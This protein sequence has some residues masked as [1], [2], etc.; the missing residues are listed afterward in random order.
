MPTYNTYI[1]TTSY[2]Y[3]LFSTMST[4]H[5][6][7]PPCPPYPATFLPYTPRT[8]SQQSIRPPLISS[9]HS[10]TQPPNS[11]AHIT[12]PLP[13]QHHHHQHPTRVAPTRPT[14]IEPAHTAPYPSAKPSSTERSSP[15][16]A[17]PSPNS[18][19]RATHHR[20]QNGGRSPIPSPRPRQRSRMREHLCQFYA[21]NSI[22]PQLG[23]YSYPGTAYKTA[24]MLLKQN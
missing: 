11:T 12:P 19:P 6:L 4:Q 1:Q 3:P 21:P 2:Y 9:S 5:A 22:I 24:T 15:R 10:H 18:T 23:G 13:S 16:S 20:L 14:S 8:H 17:P 7:L